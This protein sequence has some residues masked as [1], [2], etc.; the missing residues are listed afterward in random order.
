MTFEL[1]RVILRSLIFT[2]G[3]NGEELKKNLAMKFMSR[4]A[5]W[6][7]SECNVKERE[8]TGLEVK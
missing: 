3:S 5:F 1:P 2:F 7:Q 4:F 8:E 6:K